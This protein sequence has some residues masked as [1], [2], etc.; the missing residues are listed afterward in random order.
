MDDHV[1]AAATR[2]HFTPGIG[3]RGRHHEIKQGVKPGLVGRPLEGVGDGGEN[4]VD[5]LEKGFQVFGPRYL[6]SRMNRDWSG[7]GNPS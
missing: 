6:D 5:R 2:Q 3:P 1:D 7:P 4:G